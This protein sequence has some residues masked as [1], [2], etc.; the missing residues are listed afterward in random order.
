[1][2]RRKTE[3][4]R[5]RERDRRQY[6]NNRKKIL[7]TQDICAICGNEV[8]KKLPKGDPWSAEIDHIIP[9]SRGGTSDIDNLQ[10]SHRRC[11][12]AKWD[13]YAREEKARG[14]VEKVEVIDNRNLPWS[15]DWT[16]FHDRKK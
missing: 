2:A 9:V 6:E 14:R 4:D 13:S 16:H 8:D 5:I 10:L 3:V 12:R 7:A 15:V 11:N 1:M